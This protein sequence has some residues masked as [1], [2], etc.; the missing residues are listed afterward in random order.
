MVSKIS[1][2]VYG[3]GLFMIVSCTVRWFW[4]YPDFSQFVLS[5]GIGFFVLLF[6]YIYDW[7]KAK[8]VQV[9]RA[10]DKIDSILL[11]LEKQYKFNNFVRNFC[12]KDEFEE[13]DK[14]HPEVE[15][16]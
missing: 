1:L 15:N 11:Q 13:Y 5:V 7:M 10:E 14:T 3:L 6:G 4:L 2:G 8:D 16:E 9:K 12:F